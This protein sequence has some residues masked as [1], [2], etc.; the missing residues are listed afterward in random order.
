MLKAVLFDLDGTLIDTAPDLANALNFVL[1]QNQLSPL[2]YSSIRPFVSMGAKGLIEHGF[3][4]ELSAKQ[5]EEI[6]SNLIGYYQKNIANE[7][8][9]FAGLDETLIYLEQNKIPWGI[10]TNKPEYLTIPLLTKM[11]LLTRSACVVC[12]DQVKNPKPHPE[13][14]YL[15][16]KQLGVLPEHT[17]CIG[18]AQRDVQA[19]RLAG[20]QTIACAYGY[21]P[22]TDNIND[23]G[24]DNIVN[25]PLELLTSLQALTNI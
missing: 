14:T 9:L 21:I 5:H 10:V 11:N 20:M 1:E 13:S 12:G 8:I 19:G 18:D 23:W 25:N 7:S 6:K 4:S 16:C 3:G 2:T 22:E 24:A 15:A 17:I